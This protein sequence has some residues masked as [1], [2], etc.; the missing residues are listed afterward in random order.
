MSEN[1]FLQNSNLD[2]YDYLNNTQNFISENLNEF[3]RRLLWSKKK[4][5][6]GVPR[7]NRP[8]NSNSLEDWVH[9]DSYLKH[10]DG[11]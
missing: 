4:K 11:N 5:I 2:E 9:S 6:M 3:A 7:E 10:A 1:Q 8:E